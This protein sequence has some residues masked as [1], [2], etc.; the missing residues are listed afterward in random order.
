MCV[1]SCVQMLKKAQRDI[2]NTVRKTNLILTQTVEDELTTAFRNFSRSVLSGDTEMC[3]VRAEYLTMD[4]KQL[5]NEVFAK[6]R[7]LHQIVAN[8]QISWEGDG[9][10][11]NNHARRRIVNRSLN[12]VNNFV[13]HLCTDPLM[14]K[15]FKVHVRSCNVCVLCVRNVLFVQ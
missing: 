12:V 3:Q 10:Y 1:W 6:L 2:G 11:G 13:S 5:M 15:M 14:Q 9:A 4:A 7:K 8:T